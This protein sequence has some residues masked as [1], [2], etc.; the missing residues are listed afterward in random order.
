VGRFVHRTVS[1]RAARTVDNPLFPVNYLDRE[2]R[3]D[4]HEHARE[5]TCFGRNVNRQM[6]RSALYC[7]WH[8]F[9]KLHR[10]RGDVRSH[11]EVSGQDLGLIARL[12]PS[13]WQKRAWLS[14]L[15]LTEAE[16]ETWLRLRR[17]PLK[18]EPDYLPKYARA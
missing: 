3:K 6:E 4:L 9:R 13:I 11:A 12:S 8:N 14:D 16:R 18:N 2:I 17:T 7:Y 5:T 15:A 1:S 10:A